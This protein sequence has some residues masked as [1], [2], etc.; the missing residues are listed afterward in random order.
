MWR[1]LKPISTKR[2]LWILLKTCR[3]LHAHWM[4]WRKWWSKIHL[5]L[6]MKILGDSKGA[7][8]DAVKGFELLTA[9]PSNWARRATAERGKRPSAAL[10]FTLAIGMPWSIIMISCDRMNIMIEASLSKLKEGF[11]GRKS[12]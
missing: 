10:A 8:A 12:L 11:T 9:D 2:S 3:V 6:R 4:T 1:E 7:L 5:R